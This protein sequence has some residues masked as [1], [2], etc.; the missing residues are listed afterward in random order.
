MFPLNIY[1]VQSAFL[2]TKDTKMESQV[3]YQKNYNAE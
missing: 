3:L 1:Y 2:D